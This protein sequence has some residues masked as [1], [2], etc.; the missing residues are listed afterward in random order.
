MAIN[1]RIHVIGFLVA[2]SLVFLL[3]AWIMLPLVNIMAFAVIVAILFYPLYK[4][5][6]KK[7]QKPSL[8]SLL[9]VFV[10]LL[11]LALPLALFGQ[12][13]ISELIS[14]Y[15]RYQA[16]VFILD[17]SQLIA[18]L[19]PQAQSIIESFSKDFNNLIGRLSGDIFASVTTLLGNIASFI[20]AF[21]T[22]IF[23][24]YYLFKDGPK[25][26][27]VLMDLSPIASTQENLLVNKIVTA[28]NGV[29]KGSFIVAL[30]QGFVA[31]IG[32]TIFGL[33]DPWIWGA[34]TVVAALVPTFGTAIAL[35]PAVIFLFVTGN[36][37]EAIGLA[38]WGAVAVGLV[39][40]FI[41]PRLVGSSTKLHPV[42]VLL[43]ILGGLKFFGIIGF[44][45]GPII[46][47]IFVAMIEM[48]RE[49]FKD[50]IASK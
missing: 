24:I 29:V 28:V 3:V 30:V 6:L 45:I 47:A 10:I 41:G 8:A 32:Y 17:Q 15:E 34:F 27:Q 16:G 20:V 12:I 39:D 1:R 26:K 35:I 2:L 11:I 9:T 43:S 31:T 50:Y 42:L 44:L 14:L 25:L 38:I 40:N 13:I 37:P 18:S 21:F 49:E 4:L 36:T 48:Y 22:F 7:V 5:I 33:P 23:I 19:P 46:M